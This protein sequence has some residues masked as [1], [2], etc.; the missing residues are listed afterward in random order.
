[1][2]NHVQQ[3]ETHVQKENQMTRVLLQMRTITKQ[4]QRNCS[5]SN[6]LALFDKW[7]HAA[8][9]HQLTVCFEH[10]CHTNN[11]GVNQTDWVCLTPE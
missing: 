10:V 11:A 4:A 3:N 1:M 6:Q 8:Q 2:T 5:S 7:T 9:C